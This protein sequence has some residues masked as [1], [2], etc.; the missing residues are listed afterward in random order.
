VILGE[1]ADQFKNQLGAVPG[2][3][4][5]ARTA[6]EQ[7]V[8]LQQAQEVTAVKVRPLRVNLPTRGLRYS[9]AQVLQTEV[10][11][12]MSVQFAATNTRTINWPLRI[13]T[14]AA[15]FVLLWGIVA[16][17]LKPKNALSGV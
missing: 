9:F 8:K 10:G 15:A 11:K 2:S 16:L 14:G 12:P 3:G 6:E 13:A 17:A 1:S 5:A 7:W 4:D